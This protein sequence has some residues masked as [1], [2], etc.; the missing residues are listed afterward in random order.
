MSLCVLMLILTSVDSMSL[1]RS[2]T[3]ATMSEGGEETLCEVS[4]EWKLIVL[5]QYY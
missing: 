2:E 1:Q 3:F 4:P 5:N